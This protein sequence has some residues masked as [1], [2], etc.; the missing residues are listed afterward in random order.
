MEEFWDSCS[1]E[2]HA[3]IEEDPWVLIPPYA[4]SRW[5]WCF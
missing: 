4:P 2:L 1:E 3:L 5:C